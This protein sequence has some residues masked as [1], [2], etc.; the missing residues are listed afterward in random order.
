MLT[1]LAMTAAL[2]YGPAQTDLKVTNTRTT[3]GVLGPTRKDDKEPK[4]LIGDI[5]YLSFDIEGLKVAED[6]KI[7]YSVGMELTNSTG[8]VLYREEPQPLSII[9]SLGGSKVPGFV[10]AQTGTDLSAGKYTLTAIVTDRATKKEVKEK[11][12]FEV[13]PTQFGL[14]RVDLSYD[15]KGALPAPPICVAGQRVQVNFFTTGFE[16]DGKTKQPNLSFKMRVLEN[17]KA[18]LG[19]DAAGSITFAPEAYKAIPANF[20][21]YMNRSGKFVVELE[22]LDEVTKKTAKHSFDL[23]VMDVK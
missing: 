7:E 4:L 9:N 8:K 14:I 12:D 10:A 16:R 23:T 18:V 13:L 15:E 21:I 11:K 19:K 2:A 1:A 5:L 3:Q 20:F 17:G 6:G 22:A